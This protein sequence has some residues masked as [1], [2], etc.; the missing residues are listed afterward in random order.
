MVHDSP[1]A[2]SSHG[3]LRFH[4]VMRTG[5]AEVQLMALGGLLPLE[6]KGENLT[7]INIVEVC[8]TQNTGE[9]ISSVPSC[10]L[11]HRKK[12]G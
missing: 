2:S 7:H 9:W 3:S 10:F 11:L 5:R 8:D 6:G 4:H 12:D 1:P